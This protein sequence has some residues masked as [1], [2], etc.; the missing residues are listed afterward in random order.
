MAEPSEPAGL[1]GL[2]FDAQQQGPAT[3][4]DQRHR[5]VV[6]HDRVVGEPLDA[7][8]VRI[9][10]PLL[11]CAAERFGHAHVGRRRIGLQ[12]GKQPGKLLFFRS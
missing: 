6:L 3:H 8:A 2:A 7:H 9:E 10:V 12:R 5:L 1:I 4:V 11:G